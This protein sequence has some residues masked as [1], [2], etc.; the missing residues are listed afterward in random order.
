MRLRA[1]IRWF[2]GKNKMADKLL[3]LVPEHTYYLEAFGGS[4]ALL[5][6]KQPASFEVYNDINKHLY[7][8]Y[9]VLQDKDKFQEFYRR[10]VL[11]PYHREFHNES[12]EKLKVVDDDIDIAY[13]FYVNARMGFGGADGTGNKSFG[14]AVKEISRNMSS[15]VSK[16]LSSIEMLPEIHMRLMTVQIEC[17]DWR[18]VLD[19]YNEWEDEGFFYIDPPYL[20]ETR[21]NGK[22]KYELTTEDHEELIDWL[23][24]K[25]RVK[26]MLSGYDNPLY[27]KLEE[28]GWKK[29]CWEFGC[30]AVGRTRLTGILGEGAMY[31]NNQRRL[32]CVWINYELK[33]N[34]KALELFKT[35]E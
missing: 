23:L 6:A 8:F 14:Y 4:G 2:G 30:W 24:T 34:Q 1:P 35:V 25:A 16:Y 11:T 32:E 21:R 27:R 33:E 18:V 10:V 15:E 13:W 3:A 12:R 20:P 31:K 26:V 9:K 22:Y 28:N 17:L 7:T 29:H 19:K 5:F